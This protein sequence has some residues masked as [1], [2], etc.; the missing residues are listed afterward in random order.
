MLPLLLIAKNSKLFELASAGLTFKF[1]LNIPKLW[2]ENHIGN[3][4]LFMAT[5]L[6]ITLSIA[7]G[8]LVFF[9]KRGKLKKNVGWLNGFDVEVEGAVDDER[10]W[11]EVITIFDTQRWEWLIRFGSLTTCLR[12]RALDSDID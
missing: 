10:L 7:I 4:G 12:N 8:F 2:S 6:I 9:V 5:V 1:K 11:C 3:Y